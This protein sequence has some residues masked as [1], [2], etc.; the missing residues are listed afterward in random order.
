MKLDPFGVLGGESDQFNPLDLFNPA[1]PGASSEV[2][3]F[4]ELLI[5]A[6]F[7]TVL[8][9]WRINAISLIDGILGYLSA[10]PERECSLVEPGN[11][12]EK[13]DVVYNLAVVVDT[14][15]K[16]LPPRAYQRIAAFLQRGDMERTS[17]IAEASQSLRFLSDPSCAKTV[18]KTTFNV[19]MLLEEGGLT[20]Y[21]V[22]PP[23]A[24]QTHGILVRMWLISLL[25]HF[26]Q[27]RS[28]IA[29]PP[30]LIVDN[31]FPLGLVPILETAQ[32]LFPGDILS[33][34]ESLGQTP[35]WLSSRLV[36]IHC[37]RPRRQRPWSAESR[38]RCGARLRLR[39]FCKGTGIPITRT[40]NHI[41]RPPIAAIVILLG[42]RYLHPLPASTTLC[43]LGR[44]G[45]MR[46][47]RAR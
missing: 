43:G 17:L 7:T 13:D 8:P 12:L 41:V 44:I 40:A 46:G 30:L 21:I 34:W 9:F 10:V 23:N 35:D 19:R 4:S 45:I 1:Q 39:C 29:A 32:R 24:F 36:S 42:H 22:L 11:V 6:D 28:L 18:Q 27:S 37:Q 14:I 16:R 20:I 31:A 47:E 15:G 26:R 33:F 25:F 5:P 3:T 2:L 38:G